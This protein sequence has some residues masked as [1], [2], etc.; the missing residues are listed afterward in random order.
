MAHSQADI[1]IRQGHPIR[2]EWM[3]WISDTYRLSRCGWDMATYE[4]I[5]NDSMNVVFHNRNL[6]VVAKGGLRGY[7]H[8]HSAMV[9]DFRYAVDRLENSLINIEYMTFD[10]NLFIQSISDPFASFNWVDGEPTD[11]LMNMREWRAS[12]LTLFRKLASPVEQELIVDPECVQSMLD[13]ILKIQGPMRKEIRARDKRRERDGE[14]QSKQIH[15]QIISLK[16]A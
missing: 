15:A 7:R 14:V 2:V 10:K 8:L 4:D 3:G 5:M 12:D 16:A 11:A 13:Q 9:S 6:G 1:L